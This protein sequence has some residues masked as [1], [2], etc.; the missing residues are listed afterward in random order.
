MKYALAVLGLIFSCAAFAQHR[1]VPPRPGP[2]WVCE[3]VGADQWG[4]RRVYGE[5]S[6]W[7]REAARSAFEE[8]RWER[9]YRCRVTRCTF[10]V[11]LTESEQEN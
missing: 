7:Q 8:C 4:W 11:A 1:P 3:A 9:L 10:G 2:A 5:P 6:I